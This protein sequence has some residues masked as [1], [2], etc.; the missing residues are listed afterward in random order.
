MKRKDRREEWASPSKRLKEETI[1][2]RDSDRQHFY[3]VLQSLDKDSLSSI[4][5]SLLLNHSY[6][7]QEVQG[8]LPKPTLQTV[9][10]LLQ[11]SEIRLNDAFPYSKHNPG[12]TSDYSFNRV[13]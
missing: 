13:R 9:M 12:K 2:A 3:R 10:K 5:S 8:L 4:L 7:E 6:L 11:D 1:Q